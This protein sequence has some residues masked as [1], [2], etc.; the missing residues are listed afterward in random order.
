[1]RITIL[2][3]SNGK[4]T[5]TWL[6]PKEVVSLIRGSFHIGVK[7]DSLENPANFDEQRHFHN[8]HI[9]SRPASRRDSVTWKLSTS[10]LKDAEIVVV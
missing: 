3:P 2:K 5:A 6:K 9:K 1:M 7:S 8:L 4:V 10:M